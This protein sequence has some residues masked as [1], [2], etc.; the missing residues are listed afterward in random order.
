MMDPEAR[1]AALGLT[2][3]PPAAAVANY[4]PW[5]LEGGVL[6]ISGQLPLDNGAP[7]ATGAVGPGGLSVE[8]GQEAA[9]RCAVNLLAQVRAA[10]EGDWDRLRRVIRLGGYV[11]SRPGFFGHPQVLNGASDLMVAVLGDRGRHARAA[12]GVYTLPLDVPVELEGTLA[13]AR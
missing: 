9:R 4:V 10:V 8:E 5:V 13:V 3:P 12:V 1:L 11:A 7:I 2:L 6:T